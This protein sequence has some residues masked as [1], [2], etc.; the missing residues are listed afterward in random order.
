M[1]KCGV[2]DVD[3]IGVGPLWRLS[4]FI[5]VTLGVGVVGRLGASVEGYLLG[6]LMAVQ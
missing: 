4:E 5:V 6:T 1:R 3:G 2:V